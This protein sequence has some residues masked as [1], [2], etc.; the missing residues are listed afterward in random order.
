MAKI[1]GR[2][3]VVVNAKT[4]LNKA[5]AKAGGL[6]LSG[7]PA[8][9]RKA[10]MG[11]SGLHGFTE[12]PIPA[13]CEVTITDR[14]DINLSDLATINGD[15]T[16]VFRAAGGSGKTYTMDGA[17][18]TNNFELTGGEGEVTVRF[19]GAFWIEGVQ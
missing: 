4:L 12:E 7:V 6:G 18:C 19:E 10:V 13:Y 3:E 5:G 15:G 14:D 1:T 2:V 11:D 17:T 16:I 8:F 9:E